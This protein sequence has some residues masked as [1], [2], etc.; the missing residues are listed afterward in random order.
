MDDG[1]RK[2]MKKK[3][4]NMDYPPLELLRD[5]EKQPAGLQALQG[6]AKR[7]HMP[8]EFTGLTDQDFARYC[9]RKDWLLATDAENIPKEYRDVN[10][11]LIEI[12]GCL[13]P[14]SIIRK[15]EAGRA[16]LQAELKDVILLP[17][18]LRLWAQNKQAFKPDPAF[19]DALVGTERFELTRNLLTHLRANPIYL[20]LSDCPSFAPII[21][22]L[23]DIEVYKGQASMS[24][25]L[26]TKELDYFS[27]YGGGEFNDKEI[28]IV[29]MSM[30][31]VL[32]EEQTDY[33]TMAPNGE[34][35]VRSGRSNPAVSR[36][37]A[38]LF[39]LQMICYLGSKEPELTDSPLTAGTY[40]RPKEGEKPKNRRSETQTHDV[41]VRYGTAIRLFMEQQEKETLKMPKTASGT[42]HHRSPIPHF[43][44]A[45]WQRFW[46][47]TGRTVCE[48]KWIAPVFVGANGK[49]FI[50][51]ET[52]VHR[53][54]ET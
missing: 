24:V 16:N 21:G 6:I 34:T 43:R 39:A 37:Q 8:Y 27:F 47:G 41:G 12:G 30:L 22:A 33:E 44:S 14:P 2:G 3:K 23:V 28:L 48:T 26:F 10:Q 25:F 11:F 9:S 50:P 29:D 35:V 53:V 38:S 20:D 46:T 31:P 52:V 15:V 17:S 1:K 45:H 7:E 4:V 49:E 18:L 36:R 42:G 13:L 32:P 19:A 40:R 54:S 5:M 51:G